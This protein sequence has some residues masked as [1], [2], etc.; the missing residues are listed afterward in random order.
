MKVFLLSTICLLL[1]AC[2]HV[3]P[4][5]KEKL[6]SGLHTLLLRRSHDPA[7]QVELFWMEP[8]NAR[9]W[10]AVIYLHGHQEG[11]VQG[12]RAFHDWGT[13]QKAAAQGY[14]AVAVSLP[15]YGKSSG[16]R[17]FAGVDSQNAVA[18]V[19]RQ[20][21]KRPEVIPEKVA[22]VGIS[23]GAT[24]AAK[25]GENVAGLAALVL[26]SGVYDMAEM[27]TKWRGEKSAGHKELAD[28]F[29]VESAMSDAGPT[30]LL[31]RERSVLPDPQIRAPTLIFQGGKDQ[32]TSATQA[33]LLADKLQRKGVEAKA[34]V[35]PDSMHN[36]PVAAR[37]REIDPFL[38]KL[39]LK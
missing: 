28:Q 36:I 32:I 35:Y 4:P 10:P 15:G 23:V 12:G 18:D 33:E 7:R 37:E 39:L 6:P 38:S 27:Y 9:P 22:V 3:E 2:A 21:R 16:P 30:E 31:F 17:D 25:V 19:I 8:G 29:E 20:V 1:A 5:K 13:L 34:I 26:I 11:E 24:L 14:L